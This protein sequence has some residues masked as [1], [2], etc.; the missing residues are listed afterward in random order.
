MINSVPILILVNAIDYY[1]IWVERFNSLEGS[2]TKE[3]GKNNK[4]LLKW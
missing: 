4:V 2:I 1:K 3:L